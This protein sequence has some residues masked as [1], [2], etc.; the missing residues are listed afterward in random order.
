MKHSQCFSDLLVLWAD[1]EKERERERETKD[2]ERQRTS[3]GKILMVPSLCSRRKTIT[4]KQLVVCHWK[5]Y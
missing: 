1:M 3:W 5:S 2:H 4:V